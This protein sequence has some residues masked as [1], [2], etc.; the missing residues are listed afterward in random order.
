MLLLL[1]TYEGPK[2]ARRRDGQ[3]QR[4]EGATCYYNG[5]MLH[6]IMLYYIIRSYYNIIFRFIYAILYNTKLL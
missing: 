2:R 4:S 5:I 6:R 3:G 1:L